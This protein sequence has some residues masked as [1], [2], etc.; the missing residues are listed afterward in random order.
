MNALIILFIISYLLYAFNCDLSF[1]YLYLGLIFVYTVF[2]QY[3]FCK[4]PFNSF[5]NKTTV[6]SWG[7]PNDSHLY[8][9]VKLN[10]TEIESYLET[11][12][13]KLG[14]KITFTIYSIKLL[15]I[16]L[17]KFPELNSYI[18]YGLLNQKPRV[19]LC[20]LV[21]VGGGQDLC[22]AVVRNCDNKSIETVYD[23]LNDS[24]I[25]FRTNKATEHNKK[26]NVA[27]LLPNFILSLMVQAFSYVSSI[28]I[29]FKPFGV[30]YIKCN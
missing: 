10:V 17:S 16:I 13:N 28:G 24:V 30:S 27:L 22:N 25:K 3:V 29:G 8:G 23:E 6:S 15:S 19:D 4:T 14:K 21:E 9:K 18:K 12:S 11:L 26:N 20:C 1:I 2:T 7:S 5:R